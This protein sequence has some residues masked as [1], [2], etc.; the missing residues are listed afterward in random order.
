VRLITTYPVQRSSAAPQYGSFP[1]TRVNYRF[2][3]VVA[4]FWGRVVVESCGCEAAALQGG[5]E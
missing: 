3:V 2:P 4:W 1:G 5:A